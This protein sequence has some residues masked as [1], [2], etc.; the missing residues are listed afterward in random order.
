MY[1]TY[2]TLMLLSIPQMVEQIGTS[3]LPDAPVRP[4]R[5]PGAPRRAA[6]GALLALAGL[7][8]PGTRARR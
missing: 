4:E 5:A 3:A 8:D 1:E 6:A 7:L 2:G